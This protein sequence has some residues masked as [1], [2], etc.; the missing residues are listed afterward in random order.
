MGYSS[1]SEITVGIDLGTGNSCV[2]KWN[3]NSRQVEIIPDENG[4]TIL[5]SVIYIHK[6]TGDIKIGKEKY[7]PCGVSEYKRFS[8]IKRL[9]GR[10]WSDPETQLEIAQVPFKVVCGSGDGDDDDTLLIETPIGFKTPIEMSA[11]IL[12]KIKQ[13]VNAYFGRCSTANQQFNAVITVPAYFNDTQRQSTKCAAVLAGINV[14][15]IINEPTAAS[16]AYGFKTK[17]AEKD[18]NLVVIDIGSGTTDITVLTL[19]TDYM[20]D[21]LATGG[22]T[23]LGGIDIDCM[24]Y[25][26]LLP[27]NLVMQKKEKLLKECERAKCVL[28]QPNVKSATLYIEC[29]LAGGADWT[30][31]LSR[32]KFENIISPFF[33]K[34]L[35][36][37]DQILADAKLQ[38]IDIDHIL[39]VGG[40]S[41]IPKIHQVIEEYFCG[42]KITA[43]N[44]SE[45][46]YSP[47]HA[48]AYG[49]GLQAALLQNA[50]NNDATLSQFILSDI[51]PL[52][53]GIETEGGLLSIVLPRNTKI[54]ARMH[55]MFAPTKGTLETSVDVR[56]YEGE[57]RIARYNHFLGAFSFP[58]RTLQKRILVEFTVDEDGILV[59]LVSEDESS[60]KKQH[61]VKPNIQ[62][63]KIKAETQ[64]TLNEDFYTFDNLVAENASARTD[65]ELLCKQTIQNGICNKIFGTDQSIQ[66]TKV[67]QKLYDILK[68]IQFVDEA[69]ADPEAEAEVEITTTPDTS[70]E[71]RTEIQEETAE[72]LAMYAELHTLVNSLYTK[73]ET[74]TGDAEGNFETSIS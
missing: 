27:C 51:I 58:L 10:N 45:F 49:A 36:P 43:T 46:A 52:S 9:I 60:N 25:D 33:P 53:I 8:G 4:E 1:T 29:G 31:D 67:K 47:D 6:S 42:K 56:I 13:N 5:P 26:R 55:K 66:M 63:T 71:N 41:R 18:E 16:L 48:I 23:R 19:T 32:A 24:L 70:V 12:E 34:L 44:H 38:K 2:S 20:F 65:L 14:I 15:R 59:I 17:Q 40:T 30:F 69:E 50:Y 68:A 37:L 28:S 62:M 74:Y 21:I 7:I 61:I 35:K 64:I 54:P 22:N 73:K 11:L 39:L 57:R 72:F 3:A